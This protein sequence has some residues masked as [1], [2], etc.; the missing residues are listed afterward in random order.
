[1]CT[2]WHAAAPCSSL[3]AAEPPGSCRSRL[4]LERLGHLH[5]LLAQRSRCGRSSCESAVQSLVFPSAR[6]AMVRSRLT[7]HGVHVQLL[8][9]NGEESA[10]GRKAEILGAQ[11]AVRRA[12]D[13]V[14][15][16]LRAAAGCIP[17]DTAEPAVCDWSYLHPQTVR[18]QSCVGRP[19]SWAQ[20]GSL[21]VMA[22][23]Y[24]RARRHAVQSCAV[25]CMTP[26]A[27][28][29]QGQP[30]GPFSWERVT[31][32]ISHGKM[33]GDTLMERGDVHCWL[34]LWLAHVPAAKPAPAPS[35]PAADANG[36]P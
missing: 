15:A 8:D 33:P 22:G 14:V 10:R 4:C 32:W 1:M 29:V 12:A 30:L 35:A 16:K 2:L 24:S 9:C 28:G 3:S 34:P 23:L 27:R 11:P 13:A 17:A 6:A 18:V 36:M 26:A 19:L 5:T 25:Q 31:K 20:P 7:C 21:Q